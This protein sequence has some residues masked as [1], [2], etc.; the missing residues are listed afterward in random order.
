MWPNKMARKDC[1]VRVCF[2]VC[3][4][5]HHLCPRKVGG[6]ISGAC[7]ALCCPAVPVAHH[8]SGRNLESQCDMAAK[9]FLGPGLG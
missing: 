1:E 2:I 5:R 4:P 3:V 6:S 8:F 7:A 9:A